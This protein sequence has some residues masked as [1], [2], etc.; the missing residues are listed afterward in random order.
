VEII[1]QRVDN[2]ESKAMSTHRGGNGRFTGDSNT[3]GNETEEEAQVDR[4][5][6]AAIAAAN[7]VDT[8]VTMG[9]AQTPA[10]RSG[11]A[12]SPRREEERTVLATRKKAQLK[13]TLS[14]ITEEVEAAE[15]EAARELFAESWGTPGEGRRSKT[16]SLGGAGE[17]D[18]KEDEVEEPNCADSIEYFL[19]EFGEENDLSQDVC[20][21]AADKAAAK[22]E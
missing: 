22:A 10:Q 5:L 20:K 12:E 2:Q 4:S 3:A 18:E 21:G 6:A 1:Y 17:D 19:R 11:L 7:G 13:E 9:D 16:N 8:T 15:R 14:R